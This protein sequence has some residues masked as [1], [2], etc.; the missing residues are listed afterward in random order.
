VDQSFQLSGA[1]ERSG[2]RATSLETLR[3]M[4]AAGVGVTLLPRLAVEPPVPTS[5]DIR[6]IR[7]RE[8][9]PTRR[10]AM[11]WRRTSA[12]REF[13]P[14]VAELFRQLPEGLVDTSPPDG[15]DEV[16]DALLA[17]SPTG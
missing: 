9:V 6:L 13:L 8:P 15:L 5:E 3:Q 11:F 2:F 10:I 12:Y 7:F 4:V 14:Q 16:T 1:A 17:P